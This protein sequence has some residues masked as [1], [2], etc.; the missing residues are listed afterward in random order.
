MALPAD[1]TKATG[2]IPALKAL[3]LAAA[4]TVPVREPE[5][6]PAILLATG[7]GGAVAYA[8]PSVKQ[9]AVLVVG[10]ARGAGVTELIELML[11]GELERTM[12]NPVNHVSALITTATRPD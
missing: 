11:S 1:V 7:L 5:N 9:G 4:D 3:D 2:L 8:L 10:G 12:P 6:D